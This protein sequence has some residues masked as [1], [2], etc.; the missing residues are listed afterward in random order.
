MRASSLGT[1]LNGETIPARRD[2]RFPS[3]LPRRRVHKIP[4]SASDVL[5][6]TWLLGRTGDPLSRE[7]PTRVPIRRETREVAVRAGRRSIIDLARKSAAD[8]TQCVWI[9]QPDD[10]GRGCKQV[11]ARENPCDGIATPPDAATAT[12]R[13]RI[14]GN[15]K[16]S[17]G[18]G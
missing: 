3:F 16:V 15:V 13:A 7:V 4:A 14:A 1:V 11:F 17:R 10:L 5:D 9:D 2:Q 18:C 12:R 6:E 8:S